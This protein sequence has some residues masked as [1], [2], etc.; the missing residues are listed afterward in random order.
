MRCLRPLQIL[1]LLLILPAFGAAA[2]EDAAEPAAAQEEKTEDLKSEISDAKSEKPEPE[3]KSDA[4]DKSK[5]EDLKPEGSDS[6]SEKQ[7]AEPKPKSDAGDKKAADAPEESKPAEPA[8]ISGI[9]STDGPQLPG[10]PW[11]V[12]D[13]F[14]PQP[15]VVTPADTE[16]TVPPPSDALVLF[17][18]TDLALW[19]HRD[20]E[21]P[22]MFVEPQWKV[23]NGYFQ[24]SRG[25]GDLYTLDSFGSVQLHLEW[26]APE[27]AKGRSQGRGNSGVKFLG[28]YE[29]QILD[30]YNN[31]TYADGHAG[32]IYGQYPPAVNA[33]RPPGKWQS[34]DIIFEIPKFDGDEL[35]RPGFITVLHNG[36]LVQH[37]RE[38]AGVTGMKSPGK[39]SPHPPA[40][41]IMLQDHG[42]PVRFRN[43]WVR[44][45]D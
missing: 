45:L 37:R 18:G 2:Q 29:V 33:S 8:R 28:L 30:S 24:A 25:H 38:L 34:Y 40:G 27:E 32:A 14:R 31:R 1:A 10:Q 41:P 3:P 6:N 4:G 39:Y 13:L 35:V 15:R 43:V 44:S 17:D 36:V 5:P 21:E 7:E 20:R 11:R 42:N 22:G 16:L 26:A 12:H 9:G 19:G 23:E